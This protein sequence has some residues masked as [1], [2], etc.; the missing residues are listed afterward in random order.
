MV[1]KAASQ[2]GSRLLWVSARPTTPHS[3]VSVQPLTTL[4]LSY[5]VQ[6]LQQPCVCFVAHVPGGASH[7]TRGVS[8][9]VGRGDGL[10]FSFGV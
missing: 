3:M 6:T 1:A 8:S 5:L 10:N 7:E 4:S 2:Q 9:F